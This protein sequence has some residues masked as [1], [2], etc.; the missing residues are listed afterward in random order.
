M[1]T[2]LHFFFPPVYKKSPSE[3]TRIRGSTLFCLRSPARP[4]EVLSY[5]VRCKGRRPGDLLSFRPSR[6]G[7]QFSHL[8]CIRFHYPDSLCHIQK[9]Y[10]FLHRSYY[11]QELIFNAVSVK[12]MECRS[13]NSDEKQ[14]ACDS[15][16]QVVDFSGYH[17]SH[18][19]SLLFC[20]FFKSKSSRPCKGTRA[21]ASC[22]HPISCTCR[23]M[24]LRRFYQTLTLYREFPE[25][26]TIISARQTQKCT[27]ASYPYPLSLSGPALLSS[28][29]YSFLHRF[30]VCTLPRFEMRVNKIF[31]KFSF[32]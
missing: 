8:I 5:S 31:V 25:G 27:S 23:Q 30:V 19:L 21:I 10:S 3:G 11:G 26:P 7:M 4:H 1:S 13:G 16:C 12:L 20:I 15:S 32:I 22:F 18:R 6:S 28:D 9:T 29:A 24:H 2:S 14:A 17:F